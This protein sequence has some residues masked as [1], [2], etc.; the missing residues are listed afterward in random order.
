MR[1]RLEIRKL[2][3][4]WVVWRDAGEWDRFAT[5]W[6]DD[7]W[8]M[9][10]WFQAPAHDFIAR[11]RQAFDAGLRVLHSVGGSSIDVIGTRAVS[12]TKM[13]ITQRAEVHEV[14]VDVRCQ[15]RFVDAWEQREGRWGMVM[16]QPV[17][18]LDAM[19]PVDPARRLIWTRLCLTNFPRATAISP[20]FR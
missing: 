13:E 19:R 17:Y 11:G 14:E 20:T 12:H 7:G 10:T 9:A 6:H 2:I 1:D 8:M 3:E 5:V 4:N 15:G 18:E 16:R